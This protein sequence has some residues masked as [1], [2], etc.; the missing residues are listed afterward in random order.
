MDDDIGMKEDDKDEGG[1]K[2][3]GDNVVLEENIDVE[4]QQRG[5]LTGAFSFGKK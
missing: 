4:L 1:A 3:G 5:I 2:H